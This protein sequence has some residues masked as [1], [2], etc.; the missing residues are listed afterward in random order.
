MVVFLKELR[1]RQVYQTAAI[2]VIGARVNAARTI[3]SV[4]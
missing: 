3:Q 4:L 1:R 2:Y